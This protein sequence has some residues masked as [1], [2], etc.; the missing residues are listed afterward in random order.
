MCLRWR[1]TNVYIPRWHS[2]ERIGESKVSARTAEGVVGSAAVFIS[3]KLQIYMYTY[4][5][6]SYAIILYVK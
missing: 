6:R 4:D 2:D 1:Y 3:N 5:T